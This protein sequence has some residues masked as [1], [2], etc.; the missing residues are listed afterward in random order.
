MKLVWL[1]RDLRAVDNTAL[2]CAIAS[3]E[4]VTAVFIATPKQWHQH[5]MA[6]RQADLIYRR[7][8]ALQQELRALN[9]PLLYKEVSDFEQSANSIVEIAKLCE[10]NEV[11][12]N[13]DYEVNEQAR[14]K[15]AQSESL[16]SLLFTSLFL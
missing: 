1:R 13:Q 7:L 9:I 4:P 3:G 10:V 14:D 2:N 8:S 15:Q 11:L 6:P 12:V 16:H 5:H